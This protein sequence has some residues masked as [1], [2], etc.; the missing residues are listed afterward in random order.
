MA[1]FGLNFDG[2]KKR[3][4][5]LDERAS[6]GIS[7]PLGGSD[8]DAIRSVNEQLRKIGLD[9][10]ESEVRRYVRDHRRV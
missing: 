3:L 2:M 4:R 10:D 8:E 7:V 1:G 9:P 6:E 5:D